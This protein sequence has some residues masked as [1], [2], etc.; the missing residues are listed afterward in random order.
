MQTI[1]KYFDL[2]F[3]PEKVRKIEL[4]IL[5]AARALI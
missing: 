3:G 4:L 5:R 2:Y 1:G